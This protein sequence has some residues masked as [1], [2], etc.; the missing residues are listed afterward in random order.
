MLHHRHLRLRSLFA[1][2]AHAFPFPCRRKLS[3]VPGHTPDHE[4]R[5]RHCS[6]CHSPPQTTCPRTNYGYLRRVGVG[7]GEFCGK[8][9]LCRRCQDVRHDHTGD[10]RLDGGE[11]ADLCRSGGSWGEVPPSTAVSDR[12]EKFG[13]SVPRKRL[14]LGG[15]GCKGCGAAIQAIFLFSLGPGSGSL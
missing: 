1:T 4:F 7:V 5:G 14:P 13:V 3:L 6:R 15:S 2:N 11:D 8:L 10:R 12:A 9:G